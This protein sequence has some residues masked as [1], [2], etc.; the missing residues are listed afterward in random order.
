MVSELVTDL[1]KPGFPNRRL[2]T[3]C[4]AR[5]CRKHSSTTAGF[6]AYL[7]KSI[8]VPTGSS[9]NRRKGLISPFP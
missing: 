2:V 1:P 4:T 6:L 3:T 9:V 8:R 5:T 7:R